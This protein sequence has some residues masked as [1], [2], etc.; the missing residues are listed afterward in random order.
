M[1][2]ICDLNDRIPTIMDAYIQEKGFVTPVD[3]LLELDVLSHRV[4]RSWR[5][6]SVPYLEKLCTC[7]LVE[8][9]GILRE[10]RN[11]AGNRRLTPSW[12]CYKSDRDPQTGSRH[13]LRFSKNNIPRLEQQYATHYLDR[14]RLRELKA[15]AVTCCH[16]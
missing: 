7:S 14:N 12:S 11:H 10:M 1:F 2:E 8:L 3:V 16:S 9:S 6:G 15:S 4:L 5:R 13:M